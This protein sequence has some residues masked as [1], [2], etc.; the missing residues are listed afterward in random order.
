MVWATG[1]PGEPAKDPICEKAVEKG[2]ALQLAAGYESDLTPRTFA[3]ELV[4]L[5][6]EHPLGGRRQLFRAQ[7]L[8]WH[9][10]KNRG[11]NERAT[12]MFQVLQDNKALFFDDD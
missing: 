7:C 2:M 3:R 1:L 6:G 5:C 8:R 12:R 11:D 10:D 4:R 9:P